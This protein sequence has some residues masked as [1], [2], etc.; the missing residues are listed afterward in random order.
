MSLSR[1]TSF[2]LRSMTSTTLESSCQPT[3]TSS[4]RL[5]RSSSDT[6]IASP[7]RSPRGGDHT[8]R[9]RIHPRGRHRPRAPPGVSIPTR[10]ERHPLPCPGPSRL[11]CSMSARAAARRGTGSVAVAAIASSSRP[12]LAQ[13]NKAARCRRGLLPCATLL[14]LTPGSSLASLDRASSFHLKV[15]FLARTRRGAARG[16]RVGAGILLGLLDKHEAGLGALLGL[17]DKHEVGLSGLLGLLGRNSASSH[18]AHE[19]RIGRAFAFGASR[20]D[21]LERFAERAAPVSIA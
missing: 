16:Q 17:L 11:A 3:P 4:R 18:G 14:T 13:V 6:R 9:V 21:L 7:S 10:A 5:K 12:G 20:H 1:S 19:R 2:R 8:G 15:Y